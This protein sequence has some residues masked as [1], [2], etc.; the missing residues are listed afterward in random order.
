MTPPVLV[1]AS[2]KPEVC[3]VTRQRH[4]ADRRLEARLVDHDPCHALVFH[5]RADCGG[6]PG[7]GPFTVPELAGAP[8]PVGCSLRRTLQNLRPGP[9]TAARWPLRTSSGA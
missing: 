4:I 1:V 5:Q 7:L 2:V 3:D 8:Q 9:V 6:L